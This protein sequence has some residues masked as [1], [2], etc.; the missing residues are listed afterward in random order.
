MYSKFTLTFNSFNF[1]WFVS[2]QFIPLKIVVYS[3]SISVMLV[4]WDFRISL[5]NPPLIC[6][7]RW[8]N[9]SLF[10]MTCNPSQWKWQIS[11]WNCDSMSEN[12]GQLS[13]ADISL[14]ND[15]LTLDAIILNIFKNPNTLTH[16]DRTVYFSELVLYD[17]THIM[18]TMLM[19]KRISVWSGSS[20]WH[21]G[22]AV[23]G[24]SFVMKD[25]GDLLEPIQ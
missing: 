10:L 20:W 3:S 12:A 11:H 6:L 4:T 2:V 14:D 7:S 1:P 23:P 19:F 18:H 8:S 17:N 22:D 9:V 15:N 21:K 5:F 13:T 16:C 25:G 24:E